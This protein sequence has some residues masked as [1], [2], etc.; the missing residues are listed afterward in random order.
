MQTAFADPNSYAID[1]R[2]AMYSIAY[3]SP[4]RLGAAQFYLLAIHDGAGRPLEGKKT[5]RRSVPAHA[6]VQQ[7]WSATAYD[8]QTHALIREVSRASLASN[9]AD[10]QKNAD[11]SVDVSFGPTAPAGKESNWV[12]TGGRDFEVLFR[13][14]GPE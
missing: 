11:G 6:P 2:A 5:Y 12:P 14:Y 13:F 1:G 8:R 10:V 3:F 7:Y 4:K 9:S